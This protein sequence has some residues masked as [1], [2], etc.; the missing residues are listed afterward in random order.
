MNAIIATSNLFI[1]M[2]VLTS[3]SGRGNNNQT[4]VEQQ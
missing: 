1:I 3:L 2:T 4:A